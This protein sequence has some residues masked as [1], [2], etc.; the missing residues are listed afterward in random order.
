MKKTKTKQ[1]KNKISKTDSEIDKYYGYNVF[2]KNAE[3]FQNSINDFIDPNYLISP[4]DEIIIMLWGE[5]ELNEPYT[6][7][8][9][10]IFL[11]II[12]VKFLLM[13]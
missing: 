8:K 11:L 2:S 9:M 5:T 10:D 1:I 13:V 6:V 3:L 7:T 4:G 12:L